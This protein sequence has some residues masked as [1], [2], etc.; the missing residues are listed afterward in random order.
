[1]NQFTTLILSPHIDDEILGCFSFL[2]T[3]TFVLYFGVEDRPEISREGRI[4]ELENCA[5][6]AEFS[7]EVMEF[8]VN[9]YQ[10]NDLL[11]VIE[12][13]IN[14]IQPEWIVIPH[15]SYNQ[16]HRTV[17]EAAFTALRPHDRNFFV[18]KVLIFEQPHAVLWPYKDFE[19][20]YFIEIDIDRKIELYKL[21]QSQVKSHRSPEIIYALAK[22]RG[23]QINRPFAEAFF[24]KRFIS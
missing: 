13:T 11:S 5:G 24:V 16:D 12:S 7:W 9:H 22:L 3:Q 15:P 4:K 23:A 2:N 1:M 19:P 10:F 21:Y 14:C 17:F 6:I 8:E 20:N 18:N